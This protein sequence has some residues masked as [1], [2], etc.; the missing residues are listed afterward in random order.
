M[1]TK[2][3]VLFFEK[4]KANIASKYISRPTECKN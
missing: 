2:G 3:V 4:K 1:G